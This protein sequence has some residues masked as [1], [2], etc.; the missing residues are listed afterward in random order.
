MSKTPSKPDQEWGALAGLRVLDVGNFIAA[1]FAATLMAEHGAEVL[2]I[3]LPNVGDHARR[4]VNFSGQ[5]DFDHVVMTV[6][7]GIVAFPKDA[8]I[9]LFA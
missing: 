9:L 2:K 7:I 1:P 3:E 8:P 5:A 4:R 6:A